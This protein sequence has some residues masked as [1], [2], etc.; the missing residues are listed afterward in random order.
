MVR[1]SSIVVRGIARVEV[2]SQLGLSET[3]AVAFHGPSYMTSAELPGGWC[4]VSAEEFD[5]FEPGVAAA[6]S[7]TGDVITGKLTDVAMFSEASLYSSGR[8]MWTV[9]RDV[10][11][12]RRDLLVTG[13]PP[14]VLAE[15]RGR[16]KAAQ[17]GETDEVDH[18]FDA[19]MELSAALCGFRPDSARLPAETVFHELMPTKSMGKDGGAALRAKNEALGSAVQQDIHRLAQELGF[20][21]VVLRPEHNVYSFGATHAFVR[22]RG[23]WAEGLE[24]FWGWRDGVPLIWY[25]FFVRRGVQP[26][27][28][29]SGS[30]AP[31]R[32][33]GIG[34][35]LKSFLRKPPSTEEAIRDAVTAGRDL[36]RIVDRHLTDGTPH[37]SVRPAEYW[38]DRFPAGAAAELN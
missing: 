15:I 6:L 22:L 34:A 30:A 12:K 25:Y 38:D 20:E 3:G 33:R 27:Y 37:S 9:S 1:A 21:P 26:R 2:L 11:K 36:L 24:V 10:E 23:E 13:E 8:A 32:P 16:L 31:G 17:A 28:G 29:R 4:V 18:L 7:D 19:P 14:P 5:R 35:R